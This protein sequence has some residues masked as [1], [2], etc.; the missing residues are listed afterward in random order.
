MGKERQGGA[1]PLASKV[2]VAGRNK[3]T[4]DHVWNQQVDDGIG[5]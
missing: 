4:P 2:T 1:M 5:Y 3:F